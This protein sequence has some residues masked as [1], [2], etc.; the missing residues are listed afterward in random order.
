MALYFQ[1]TTI[2]AAMA[3]LRDHPDLTIVAGATDVYPARAAK[4]GWGAA[5]TPPDVLDISRISALR[6]LED[7]GDHWWIGA[8]TTW[9]EIMRAPVPPLFDGL[10]AAARE[11]GGV[12]IQN[13]GT[14]GGNIMT[15]SPAG[16]SIPCL[17]ALD[18]EVEC[19]GGVAFRVPI[20]R[21]I[22]GY[23]KTALTPG[24]LVTGVRVAKQAGEGY[25]RKLGARRH[26]VISIAMVAGVIARDEDGSVRAARVAVGACAAR[27]VRLRGVEQ[28][29]ICAPLA[30]VNITAEH[31]DGLAPI[32]DV[33]ASASY[34]RAATLQLVRDMIAD[35][36]TGPSS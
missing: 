33:R 27:A 1:P 5:H 16:D 12:Q 23:R 26:L 28:A 19:V 8:A 9:T 36:G 2:E 14:I 7:R 20:D 15:A 32:D 6:G 13:R 34:R 21:F 24:E 11:I 35:A 17:L 10:K 25:F 31:L 4:I 30:A 22:T 18:A 29:L 3:R